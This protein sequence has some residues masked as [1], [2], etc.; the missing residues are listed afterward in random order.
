MAG[1]CPLSR[2]SRRRPPAR[3]PSLTKQPEAPSRRRRVRCRQEDLR[4]AERRAGRAA[5]QKGRCCQQVVDDGGCE[6]TGSVIDEQA[7]GGQ[8]LGP[9]TIGDHRTP[10]LDIVVEMHDHDVERVVTEAQTNLIAISPYRID[11]TGSCR[12]LWSGEVAGPADRTLVRA[13]C[14]D[15][16]ATAWQ[17]MDADRVLTTDLDP[18]RHLVAG[19]QHRAQDQGSLVSVARSTSANASPKPALITARSTR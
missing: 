8:D 18:R 3:Y 10:V 4:L 5:R 9:E 12:G 11:D 13:H 16:T 6:R 1:T 14:I 19:K 7:R 17:P 15:D 2:N